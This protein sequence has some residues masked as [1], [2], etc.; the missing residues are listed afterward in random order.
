VVRSPEEKRRSY[1]YA[2]I[3]L[4]SVKNNEFLWLSAVMDDIIGLERCACVRN[5]AVT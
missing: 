2:E 4:I 3:H 5:A 1:D